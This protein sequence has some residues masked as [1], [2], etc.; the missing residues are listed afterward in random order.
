[1]YAYFL[2][3]L[4]HLLLV[5]MLINKDD[6][7]WF[8]VILEYFYLQVA[9]VNLLMSVS[10]FVA[11]GVQGL[12]SDYHGN[13]LFNRFK[14]HTV[15]TDNRCPVESRINQLGVGSICVVLTCFC[16]M[17]VPHYGLWTSCSSQ[18]RRK[19][20]WYWEGWFCQE[21]LPAFETQMQSWGQPKQL[22]SWSWIGRWNPGQ[23]SYTGASQ[24]HSQFQENRRDHLGK[25]NVILLHLLKH[26]AE[27]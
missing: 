18:W 17:H 13:S 9:T 23:R 8:L 11:T 5:W 1:M 14:V 25:W 10:H 19:G 7:T 3:V 27:M 15:Y 26:F 20:G 16:A 6:F 12:Y 24:T 21:L 22:A 2:S 4:P